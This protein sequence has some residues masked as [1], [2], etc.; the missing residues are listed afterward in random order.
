ML[1]VSHALKLIFC[2]FYLQVNNDDLVKKVLGGKGDSKPSKPPSGSKKEREKEGS[3]DRESSAD[4]RKKKEEK[5]SGHK[6]SF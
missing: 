4:R 1:H 2:V 3:K 6:T 5:V